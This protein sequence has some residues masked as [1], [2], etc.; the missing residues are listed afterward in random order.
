VRLARVLVSWLLVIAILLG[1][2]GALLTGWILLR[3]LPQHTGT[4]HVAGLDDTVTV[5]RDENGFVHIY[6]TTPHDLFLAQGYVHASERMWQMEVFR[7]VGAGRLS[8]LFGKTQ[9]D[10]DK[11]VRTLGWYRAAE[12]DIAASSPEVRASLAAYSEGVNA[13]LADNQYLSLPFVVTGLLS[14]KGGFPDGFRPE[15]WTPADSAVFA[16]TQGWLLSGNFASEL[17][18]FLLARR[19]DAK[20]VG[21]LY[22]PPDPANPTIVDGSSSASIEGGTAAAQAPAP[23]DATAQIDPVALTRLL[24]VADG[25]STALGAPADSAMLGPGSAGSNEWAVSPERSKSG[26]A[27]LANDPHLAVSMPSVWFVVGLHCRPLTAACPYDV[28]GVSF[29][30]TPGVILG[31][32]RHIAWG[33]TNSGADV[34]DLFVEKLAPGDPTRYEYKGE[35]RDFETRR[36]TIKVAGSDDVTLDVRSTVHGPVLDDVVKPL[37]PPEQEGGGLEDP[38]YVM[39]LRWTALAGP[40]TSLDTFLLLDRARDYGAFRTALRAFGGPA[41]NFVYA[42]DEGHIAYQLA[43]HIPIRPGDQDGSVPVPGWDGAADWTGYIPFD[44]LPHLLDPPG[45]AI[46]TANNAPVGKDYPYFL[47]REWDAGYRAA[48]ITELLAAKKVF[49]TEDFRLMQLDDQLLRAAPLVAAVA[50]AKPATADGKAVR[51]RVAQWDGSASLDSLGAAAGESLA[52]RLVRD[53][54]D[55]ELG[56]G[57]EKDALARRYV[58]GAQSRGVLVRMLKDTQAGKAPSRWWDDVSTKDVVETPEDIVDRALDQAGADLRTALGDPS[59]WTWGRL[60]RMV[61]REPTLGSS[62]IAP[63]EALFDRGP[64]PVAGSGDAVNDTVWTPAVA[65]PDPYDPAYRPADLLGV[66]ETR[67]APSYRGVYDTGDW[68]AASIVSTTGQS[69]HPMDRHFADLI[70]PWLAGDLLPF[71]FSDSAV[72]R[73]TTETLTLAP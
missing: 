52:Y 57:V 46:V 2:S 62:G 43:G 18:R 35:L 49:S 58:G 10:T 6:A 7:R 63:F 5:R 30:S 31:H 37:A 33:A 50:D 4:L 65:Y 69:E 42:D 72:K 41:Q 34:E 59:Q 53:V 66:F 14:G 11:L 13:W 23:I 1:A 60:H 8:E 48:R 26:F 56:D 3:S 44:K 29:P 28:A 16:K 38:G 40:E 61:Y 24:A 12:A 22:S 15:P 32:N 54:F 45:G 20:A 47:G 17:F 36:E 73:A 64:Q 55:D 70:D 67:I 71:P 21:E 51:A 9:L 27:L 68:D 25:P 39:A 19:V